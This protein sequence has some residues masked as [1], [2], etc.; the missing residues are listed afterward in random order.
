MKPNA[1][2]DGSLL[3]SD[4]KTL[5][6]RKLIHRFLSKD[7]YWAKGISLELVNRSIDHSLCFG[8]YLE[9]KQAGFARVISDFATFAWLSDVFILPEHRGH[10]LGKRLV[11]AILADPRLKDFRRFMLAT[12]DA[13]GLYAQFGFTAV[14]EVERFMEIHRPNPYI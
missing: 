9:G 4:D 7:S 12:Q 2:L 1:T 8:L 6:D 13:Q 5:L 3:I 10:G 11:A 14:K